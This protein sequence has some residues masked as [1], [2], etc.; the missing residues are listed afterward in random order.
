MARASNLFVRLVVA[1]GAGTLL[2]EMIMIANCC[3]TVESVILPHL[4][5]LGKLKNLIETITVEPCATDINNVHNH[6]LI[7]DLEAFWVGQYPNL[8]VKLSKTRFGIERQN[9]FSVL[10]ESAANSA[11]IKYL[12]PFK[13]KTTVQLWPIFSK[14][15]KNCLVIPP[16]TKVFRCVVTLEIATVVA[17]FIELLHL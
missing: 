2:N 4:E 14:K 17:S 16:S 10:M 15:A 3:E 6:M 5:K 7:E 13:T 12:S 1:E 9:A 8:N 11:R